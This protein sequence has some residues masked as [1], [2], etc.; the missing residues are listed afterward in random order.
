LLKDNYNNLHS[1]NKLLYDKYYKNW[2]VK[3][4]YKRGYKFYEKV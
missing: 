3:I 4:I 2:K 1:Q